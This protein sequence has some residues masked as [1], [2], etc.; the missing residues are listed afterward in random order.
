MTTVLWSGN[1]QDAAKMYI[2]DNTT[3]TN[4]DG[5]NGA[6]NDA[7]SDRGKNSGNH[8]VTGFGEVHILHA[9]AGSIGKGRSTTV[10]YFFHDDKFHLIA[11]GEHDGNAYK[12]DKGL[13]QDQMPFQKNK[14]VSATGD[15]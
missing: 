1:S 13:G 11:V 5:L 8:D 4:L 10:F 12:I 9:S 2:E 3:S 6:L 14:K 15:G 7:F